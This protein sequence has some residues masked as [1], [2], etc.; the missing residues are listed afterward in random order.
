MSSWV[1]VTF[2]TTEPQWELPEDA[3]T[4]SKKLCAGVSL[5]CS[6]QQSD[7]YTHIHSFADSFLIQTMAEYWVEISGLDC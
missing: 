3:V 6:V 1:P 7:S 5:G 4:V 2:L